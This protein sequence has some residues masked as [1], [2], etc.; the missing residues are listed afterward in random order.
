MA[1]LTG[2]PL[3][4]FVV[5]LLLVFSGPPKAVQNSVWDFQRSVN[6]EEVEGEVAPPSRVGL[7][8]EEMIE[9]F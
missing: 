8:G 2:S 1:W 7:K 5:L 6:V 4:H 3:K 9:M